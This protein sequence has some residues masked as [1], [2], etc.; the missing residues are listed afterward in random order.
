MTIIQWL[1]LM[2]ALVLSPLYTNIRRTEY[3]LK[4]IYLDPPPKDKYYEFKYPSTTSTNST[5]T[6]MTTAISEN[7]HHTYS[8]EQPEIIS[9][10]LSTTFSTDSQNLTANNPIYEFEEN[11]T[12]QSTY[13]FGTALN[14]TTLSL[15]SIKK[16]NALGYISQFQNITQAVPVTTLYVP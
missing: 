3:L 16:R 2:S 15:H 10:N 8:T 11:I 13:I 7:W 1:Q 14:V 9:R 5:F 4:T 12:D 6:T